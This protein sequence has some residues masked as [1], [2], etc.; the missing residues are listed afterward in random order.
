MVVRKL[1]MLV[2]GGA[3]MMAVVLTGCSDETITITQS[4][5]DNDV[6]DL[7][8]SQDSLFSALTNDYITV[9]GPVVLDSS[10]DVF[11]NWTY[12]NDYDI[13]VIDVDNELNH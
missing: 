5:Q 13:T 1:L 3:L 6:V 9:D 8:A 4:P 2:V 10:M 11:D 12:G 7:R